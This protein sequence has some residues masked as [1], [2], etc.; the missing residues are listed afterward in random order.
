M[1][2]EYKRKKRQPLQMW[3]SIAADFNSGVPAEEIAAK[4]KHKNGKEYTRGHV[5]WVLKKLQELG[6]VKLSQ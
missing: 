3:L 1:E 5:Y 4:H 6:Y 2:I